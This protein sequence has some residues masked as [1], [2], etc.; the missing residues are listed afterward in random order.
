VGQ[1]VDD[2]RKFGSFADDGFTVAQVT[3]G[4]K[5]RVEDVLGQ[6]QEFVELAPA[7]RQTLE[8]MGIVVGRTR[9]YNLGHVDALYRR[10]WRKLLKVRG[11][12]LSDI[13]AG[14][15]LDLGI[16]RIQSHF[17]IRIFDWLMEQYA[18]GNTESAN[19]LILN[20]FGQHNRVANSSVGAGITAQIMRYFR[21]HSCSRC[22]KPEMPASSRND[23]H[24][25]T[26]I[27][28]NL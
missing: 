20:L 17:E 24:E 12:D 23:D 28:I 8:T 7:A 27:Q 26:E 18:R 11:V 22:S 9:F 19:K 13:A 1:I 14:H 2:L 6:G 16:N 10:I 21:G 5:L 15:R 4:R 3:K 25:R